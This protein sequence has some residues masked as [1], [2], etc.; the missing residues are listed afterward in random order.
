MGSREVNKMLAPN[1]APMLQPS[2]RTT[3][4]GKKQT[5]IKQLSCWS[6][7][8]FKKTVAIHPI[9]MS[10]NK[11]AACCKKVLR[12]INTLWEWAFHQTC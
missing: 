2:Q 12:S 7:F 6:P 3:P 8:Q 10:T 1:T 5:R 9:S 4:F 11:L